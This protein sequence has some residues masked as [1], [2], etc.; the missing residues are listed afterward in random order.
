MAVAG[1]VTTHLKVNLFRKYLYYSQRSH[2][3]VPPPELTKA[4][5]DDINELVTYGFMV[6]FKIASQT[7]KVAV[8]LFFLV[9]KGFSSEQGGCNPAGAH[10]RDGQN[11]IVSSWSREVRSLQVNLEKEK[12]LHTATLEELET[13]RSEADYLRGESEHYRGAL[14]NVTS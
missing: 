13:H 4:I 11:K 12:H 5:E 6:I 14:S 3:K 10:Q 9:H 1:K 7:V 8:I 2:S